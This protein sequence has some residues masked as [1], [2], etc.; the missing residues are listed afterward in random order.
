MPMDTDDSFER[1]AREAGFD[2]CRYGGVLR[3]QLE[4]AGGWAEC[5]IECTKQL[6]RFAALVAEECINIVEG[7][8]D[9]VYEVCDLVPTIVD[10]IRAKFKEP[11]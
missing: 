6:R 7:D 1:L 8:H 4:Q 11:T 2:P 3:V 9:R 10:A 5:S